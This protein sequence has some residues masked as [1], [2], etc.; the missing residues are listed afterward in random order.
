M[1]N[2]KSNQVRS[3][4]ISFWTNIMI[5]LHKLWTTASQ[6]SQSA[7]RGRKD[8]THI[9]EPAD[10]MKQ[11]QRVVVVFRAA[12]QQKNFESGNTDWLG[13]MYGKKTVYFWIIFIQIYIIFLKFIEITSVISESNTHSQF[14]S[15]F[16]LLNPE[17]VYVGFILSI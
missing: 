4:S 2:E 9:H 16:L 6:S 10:I 3:F 11:I 17:W 7:S 8:L 15:P 1:L 14:P 12:Q 5:V 13:S